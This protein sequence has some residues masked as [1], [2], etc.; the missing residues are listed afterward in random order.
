MRKSIYVFLLGMVLLA[1]CAPKEIPQ[2]GPEEDSP[3]PVVLGVSSDVAVESKAAIESWSGNVV[4]VFGLKREGSGYDYTDGNN[5]VDY[6]V[7]LS[8]GFLS[9]L[10]IYSDAS[11]K[12]PYF[13]EE[14]VLYDFFGYYL[15]DAEVLETRRGGMGYSMEVQISG[16][17]DLL[18]AYTD[19]KQDIIRSGNLAMNESNLYSAHAARNGVHPQLIFKHALSRFIFVVKGMGKKY[20]L[21]DIRGLEVRTYDRGWLTVNSGE[22]GFTV[23]EDAEMTKLYLKDSEGKVITKEDVLPNEESLPLG[24]AGACLMVAPGQKEMDVNLRLQIKET[25][26]SVDYAFTLRAVDIESEQ[27][28]VKEF[29]PGKYYTVFINVYGPEE[30]EISATLQGWNKNNYEVDPDDDG[31]IAQDDIES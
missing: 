11:V 1:G 15:D 21:V 23:S 20:D 22:L 17:E 30:I 5:I 3:V 13:Y 31:V 25:K 19:R 26:E 24:G 8:S 2:T 28:L 4:N 18:Y 16:S 14:T 10:E 7:K 9:S 12:A 27:G 29:E 6:P